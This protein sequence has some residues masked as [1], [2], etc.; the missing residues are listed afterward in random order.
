MNS[1]RIYAD[2]NNLDCNGRVRLRVLGTLTDLATQKIVLH[3]GMQVILSDGEL[4]VAGIVRC[5]H[6]EGWVAEVD[7][8]LP[9]QQPGNGG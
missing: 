3:D 4:V 7:W 1:P 6:Q 8:D 2:F 9:L 5:D